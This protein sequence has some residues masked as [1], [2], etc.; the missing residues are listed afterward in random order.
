MGLH[1]AQS[2]A[3]LVEG[4]DGQPGDHDQCEGEHKKH[5]LRAQ[6]QTADP[7]LSTPEAQEQPAPDRRDHDDQR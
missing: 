5:Q 2:A 1:L 6:P 4:E 7:P 3:D